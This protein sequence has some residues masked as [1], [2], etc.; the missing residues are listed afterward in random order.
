M[1]YTC[2]PQPNCSMNYEV[3]Q[4]T[5]QK[6]KLIYKEV[7][8]CP[9]LSCPRFAGLSTYGEILSDKPE[10][11]IWRFSVRRLAGGEFLR[12]ELRAQMRS[13]RR[14]A[15]G[16]QKNEGTVTLHDSPFGTNRY[17]AAGLIHTAHTA[18]HTACGC[19][20]FRLGLRY[21]ESLGGENGGSYAC[22][23]LESAACNLGR[24]DDSRL[25]HVAVGLGS[26]VEA[27]LP[28][29]RTLSTMTE[30]SKPAFSAI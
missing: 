17:S 9:I 28:L 2:T 10:G 6:I 29:L 13:V 4:Q 5:P 14:R 19:S 3:C 7:A 27:T 26:C 8:F 12:R 18:A 24:I 16:R 11:V 23:V 30:P 22:R 20:R 21:D 25:N 1:R 15:A